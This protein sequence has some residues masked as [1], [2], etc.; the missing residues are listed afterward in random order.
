MSKSKIV[1]LVHPIIGEKEFVKE[2][3]DNIM[4]VPKRDRGGWD[5]PKKSKSNADND[6]GNTGSPKKEK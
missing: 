4:N 6:N 2:H 3:A 1:I 5:Y